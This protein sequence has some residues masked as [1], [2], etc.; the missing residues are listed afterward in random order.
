MM[1]V[2]T[3]DIVPGMAGANGRWPARQRLALGLS[4]MPGAGVALLLLGVALGPHGLGLLTVPLLASL[5]PA[6]SV[7]LAALGVFVGLDVAARSPLEGRLLGASCLCAGV[8]TVVVGGG[9]AA[10]LYRSSPV[11][12][13]SW[14]LPVLLGLCAASSSTTLP[15]DGDARR[16]A[17]ARSGNLGDVLP[18]VLSMFLLAWMRDDSPAGAAS[19]LGASIVIAMTMAVAAWLLVTQAASDSEQRVFAFGSLLL[20][21]GAAAHLSVSAPFTGFLAGLLWYAMGPPAAEALVRDMQY[22]QHPLLVMLLVVAGARLTPSIMVGGLVVGYIVFRIAGK[23]LAGWLVSNTII[24]EWPSDFG[25]GLTAPGIVG[26]AIAMNVL[27]AHADLDSVATAFAVVVLGSL[28]SELL[29]LF[30]GPR[31]LAR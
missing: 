22:L 15:P 5:D 26:V 14:L 2:S 20:L 6:V 30:I 29:S 31:E 7:A 9:V 4:P 8:S 21:G 18:I 28:G 12:E 27:Q 3:S 11:V 13:S 10:V 25:F 17:I 19:I 24:R 23:V 16:A 1:P